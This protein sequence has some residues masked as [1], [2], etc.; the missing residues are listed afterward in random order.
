M[1]ASLV[2]L[3]AAGL[4]LAGALGA[5]DSAPPP[6]QTTVSVRLVSGPWEGRAYTI[7]AGTLT[8]YRLPPVAAANHS[9][10]QLFQASLPPDASAQRLAGLDPAA[11]RGVPHEMLDG[12]GVLILELQRGRARHTVSYQSGQYARLDP[13]TAFLLG[14]INQHVPARLAIGADWLRP[15][16]PT[17]R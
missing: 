9:P 10:Q 5:L 1:A 12:G 13:T 14:Y 7:A 6:A 8:V 3:V 16:A 17:A 15:P 4:V 2:F 11:Y